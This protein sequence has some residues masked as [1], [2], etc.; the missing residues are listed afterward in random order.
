MLAQLV[1]L[2]RSMA[3]QHEEDTQ[4]RSKLATTQR[5]LEQERA[6]MEATRESNVPHYEDALRAMFSPVF[7]QAQSSASIREQSEY[8]ERLELQ[9]A[10]FN[11]KQGA[12][13]AL[14]PLAKQVQTLRTRITELANERDSVRSELND[15]QVSKQT[16]QSQYDSRVKEL[17]ALQAAYDALGSTDSAHAFNAPNAHDRLPSAAALRT[18]EPGSNTRKRVRVSSV[19]ASEGSRST[20]PMKRTGSIRSISISDVT[21]DSGSGSGSYLDHPMSS[22]DT[23]NYDEEQPPLV[24]PNGHGNPSRTTSPANLTPDEPQIS[25]ALANGAARLLAAAGVP[26]EQPDNQDVF[27]GELTAMVAA[28]Q[29]FPSGDAISTIAG[30]EGALLPIWKDLYKDKIVKFNN[31]T[32]KSWTCQ[33]SLARFVGTKWHK[34]EDMRVDDNVACTHCTDR[35]RLCVRVKKGELRQLLPLPQRLRQGAVVG[36]LDYY[37]VP[38]TELE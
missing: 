14:E 27:S 13:T 17:E 7:D 16:L 36:T 11:Q 12:A 32:T 4:A 18:T 9:N 31:I 20:Q 21:R 34:S 2:H 6:R 38:P 37:R 19:T 26:Q 22:P 15:L 35:G 1:G 3:A 30:A 5:E 28:V 25:E 23:P 24:Q 33:T 29:V 8:I 10:K